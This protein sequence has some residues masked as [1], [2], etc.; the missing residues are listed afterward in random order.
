MSLSLQCISTLKMEV[1]LSTEILVP[2]YK[3]LAYD[4]T[5]T[6]R[7]SRRP[8]TAEARVR[9][10]VLSCRVYGRKPCTVTRQLSVTVV[11]LCA[12]HP[13]QRHQAL[14][15]GCQGRSHVGSILIH[16]CEAPDPC[17]S[18]GHAG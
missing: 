7:V 1:A 17:A 10:H 11:R 18:R 13:V 6:S 5:A 16:T 15:R 9:S 14:L 3:I 2:I 4:V 8:V 12:E